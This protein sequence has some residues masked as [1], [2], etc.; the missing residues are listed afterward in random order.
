MADI[1]VVVEHLEGAFRKS[2]LSAITAAARL[3]SLS[4][5]EVDAL[6][7]GHGAGGQLHDAEAIMARRHHVNQPHQR[8]R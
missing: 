3:S 1:L 5:G 4:G 6:V 7:L 2:T 8:R